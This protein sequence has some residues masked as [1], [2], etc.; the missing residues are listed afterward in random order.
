LGHGLTRICTDKL[1]Y[2]RLSAGAIHGFNPDIGI[3]DSISAMKNDSL[4]K[5]LF[6]R[7]RRASLTV[8]KSVSIRVNLC[9]K[10][11]LNEKEGMIFTAQY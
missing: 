9:P 8:F 7:R 10:I 5:T 1:F 3:F 11:R 6:F 2:V 4:E